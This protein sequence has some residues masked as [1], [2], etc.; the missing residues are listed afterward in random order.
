MQ[1]PELTLAI[2]Y[3]LWLLPVFFQF[4]HMKTYFKAKIISLWHCASAS[5]RSPNKGNTGRKK[6]R[7]Y[8]GK[9]SN[10]MEKEDWNSFICKEKQKVTGLYH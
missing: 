3:A 8:S 2:K 10:E 4:L 6:M 7:A 9:V 5:L 1:A